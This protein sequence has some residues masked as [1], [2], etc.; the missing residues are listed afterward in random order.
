MKIQRLN[1]KNL[2]LS[3]S[4]YDH[5]KRNYSFVYA[6]HKDGKFENIP[7]L[8]KTSHYLSNCQKEIPKEYFS[9]FYDEYVSQYQIDKKKPEET[10]KLIEKFVI[11]FLKTYRQNL[12]LS[13]M[14]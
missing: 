14:I 1:I 13:L 4:I 5:Y 7:V 10:F 9:G 11:N 2:Q 3:E 8:E 12:N 6:S